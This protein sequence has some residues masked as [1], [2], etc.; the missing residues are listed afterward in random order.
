MIV[1]TVNTGSSSVRLA[2]YEARG[3]L[4]LLATRHFAR[5]AARPAVAL[6]ALLPADAAVAAVVHRVVHG[7][8]R[9]RHPC[10]IDAA[11]E[12]EIARLGRLAPLHNPVALEWLRAARRQWPRAAPVAAFDTAFYAALPEVARRYALPRE[13]CRRYALQRYGFHGLAHEALWRRWRALRPSRARAARVISLQLGAG[14]SATAVRGGRALDTSMGFSPLEGLVM[15]TRSGDVDPGLLL[16]LQRAARLAPGRLARLLN[17][18]SGLLGVSGVSAD[19]RTL[20]ASASPAAR[21]AIELYC[22]R[23]RKILGSYLAVLGGADAILFGGGVGEHAPPVRARILAD[24]AWA[25]IRLDRAANRRAVGRE[26][27][28]SAAASAT[29]IWVIPVDES[30]LLAEQALRVLRGA[31]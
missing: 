8:V 18:E 19:M 28:V 11:A 25:G 22:Y 9:L 21:L 10:R 13:L 3:G 24:F 15:A 2:A 26:A 30:R 20:L 12:R 14:C 27:R 23:V 1:V 4:R 5:G 17:A 6:A 31:R 16:Y 29:E 7:G